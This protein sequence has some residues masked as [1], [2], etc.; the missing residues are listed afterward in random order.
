MRTYLAARYSRREEM[1]GYRR[2]LDLRGIEVT[3]RWINGMHQV[4][5]KGIPIG[6]HGERLVEGDEGA[7]SLRTHFASEDIS[8]VQAADVLILFTEPPRA[9]TSSRGGRHVEFGMALALGKFMVVVGPRENLF[10]WLPSVV[11]FETWP[12]YLEYIDGL[13]CL[14]E[15]YRGES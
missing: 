13:A 5:D 12:E 14:S 11:W 1:V 3:S 2:E 8:D 7:A 6:N 10:T 9:V 15:R 4:D